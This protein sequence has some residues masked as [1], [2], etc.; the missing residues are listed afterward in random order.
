MT[1]NA[2]GSYMQKTFPAWKEPDGLEMP[3]LVVPDGYGP[4]ALRYLWIKHKDQNEE[5]VNNY[6]VE[7]NTTGLNVRKQTT[8]LQE[9]WNPHNDIHNISGANGNL[10]WRI[11][12]LNKAAQSIDYV[13]IW[14]S[15]LILKQLWGPQSEENPN[16]RTQEEIDQLRQGLY[17]SGFEVRAW[18]DNKT[19]W[20][21]VSKMRAMGWYKHFV[22]R[23]KAK[24]GCIIN[25]PWNKELNPLFGG[26]S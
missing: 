9:A 25:T 26:Q 19:G 13:E 5:F 14:R 17:E 16:G 24:D 8:H 1:I 2:D 7:G 23:Y 4:W 15:P 21:M 20:P 11:K 18:V 12:V 6:F 22:D 10:V 3:P